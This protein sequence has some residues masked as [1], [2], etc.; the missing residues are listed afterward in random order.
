VGEV[1]GE[2]VRVTDAFGNWTSLSA[3]ARVVS[4][5][6]SFADCWL[7]SG[8]SLVGIT[9]DGVEEGIVPAGS[10][11]IVGSVK[12]V[13]MEKVISLAPDYV[14]LSADLAAHRNLEGTLKAARIPYGYFRV[15][16][17]SDYKAL[18]AQFCAVNGRADLFETHVTQVEAR[19]E[20]VRE[21]MRD[22]SD[23]SFLLMRVYS[24]GIK[25]KGADNLAGV[26]L[27]E[28]ALHNIADENP[29]LLEDL[30]VEQVVSA[31]PDYIFSLSMGDEEAAA[32]YLEQTLANN[33]AWASLTAVREGRIYSLPKELFHYKPNERWDESYEYLAKILCPEAFGA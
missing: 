30:S 8:G 6:G 25:A 20:R 27:Q 9:D 12:S 1:S 5:Y 3:G 21:K 17:F 15:D 32:A 19:I 10:V 23:Q 2:G 28:F 18:M 22:C 11:E 13:D 7:L 14:I 31:D 26:I 24:T 29:F 16:T 33:P 4:C